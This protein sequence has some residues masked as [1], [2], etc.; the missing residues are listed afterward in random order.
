MVWQEKV[1]GTPHIWP[2]VI[3]KERNG[4]FL[5]R[6]C[7]REFWLCKVDEIIV[8]SSVPEVSNTLLGS[9]FSIIFQIVPIQFIAHANIVEHPEHCADYT[10][11]LYKFFVFPLYEEVESEN[12]Y[13]ENK[14]EVEVGIS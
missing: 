5:I 1:S 13:G 11:F 14:Y 7:F 10:D 9:V 8:V 12:S 6:I 2:I 3:R 4:F